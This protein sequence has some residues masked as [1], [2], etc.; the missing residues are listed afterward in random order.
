M[1][2]GPSKRHPIPPTATWLRALAAGI[3]LLLPTAPSRAHEGPEHEIEEL[4]EQIARHGENPGILIERAIEYGVLGKQNDAI[5]DLERAIRLDPGNLH[6]LREL[7]RFQFSAGRTDNA[8]ASLDRALRLTIEEPV[9]RGG[10]L[11]LRAEILRSLDRPRPA[12]DD[13]NAAIG[14]HASNPE[15][16]LL[17]S[18]LQRQEGLSKVR[19]ED[20]RKGLE[21][22]GSGLLGI[23][24]AEALLDDRQFQAALL[25]IDPELESSRIKHSW[26]L[27]RGRALVGLA[28]LPEGHRELNTALT[29]I[30][31]ILDPAR[32]D[33]SL[34][35][36]QAIAN[37]LLGNRE[38]VRTCLE[39]ARSHRLDKGTTLRI[40]QWLDS[41]DKKP[42][43]H[44][45]TADP[46]PAA[47]GSSPAPEPGPDSAP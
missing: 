37:A 6:A 16:Y 31:A 4:T 18:E 20:L 2:S 38:A 36:D 26:R 34:L 28:R 8:L 23:E 24:L 47:P 27:R 5:R 10:L 9:D 19:I 43:S 22:T 15:W 45:G 29:E 14:L 17:R 44:R 35:L 1:N 41:T 40:R 11:I 46:T 3:L 33:P 13:C 39:K 25:R 32:P 30:S 12:L 42:R 7:G 21:I